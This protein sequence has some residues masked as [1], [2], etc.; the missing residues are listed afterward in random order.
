[1]KGIDKKNK[2]L[3]N[4]KDLFSNR[5]N[6]IKGVA[7]IEG[8]EHSIIP[9][10]AFL[11]RSNVGKS[12]LLNAITKR[13]K[14]AHT[15]KTPGRTQELNFFSFGEDM[16]MMTI[17][18]M[19]G[20]GFAKASKSKIAEWTE[21]SRYYLQNRSN[22]RRVFLLIDARHDIKPSD[23]E[24]MSMLDNCAV[25]YQIILTK[26]DKIKDRDKKISKTLDSVKSHVAVHPVIYS[27]SSHKETG[28]EDLRNGISSLVD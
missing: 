12:S 4:K 22:L 9:E 21:L 11:G 2:P 7:S 24:I 10:V 26:I 1:M 27:T 25:S 8:L 18:D 6:F 14:L 3:K 13:S 23:E 19:P 20:Y 17:V 15:S 28:L 16:P 5:C